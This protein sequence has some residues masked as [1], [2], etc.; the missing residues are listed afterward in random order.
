MLKM[1]SEFNLLA[2]IA[3]FGPFNGPKLAVKHM[4]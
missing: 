3:A 4:L 2:E 1:S